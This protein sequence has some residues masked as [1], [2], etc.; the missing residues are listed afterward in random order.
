M[1]EMPAQA[2]IST[3]PASFE[4]FPVEVVTK[5]GIRRDS[6]SGPAHEGRPPR[7]W[8]DDKSG[9][10]FL[11]RGLARLLRERGGTLEAALSIRRDLE[12]GRLSTV[13]ID[14]DCGTREPIPPQRWE[15]ATTGAEMYLTGRASM[16]A[17]RDFWDG[18]YAPRHAEGDIYLTIVQPRIVA[19]QPEA[20]PVPVLV[21]SEP[22][23]A[24]WWPR[25][26]QTLVNWATDP[27]VQREAE[28]RLKAAGVPVTEAATTRAMEAMAIE[29]ER[30]WA[31]QS[32]GATRRKAR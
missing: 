11:H 32:I 10:E 22:R 24:D 19:V 15:A 6:L 3:P 12:T 27:A 25:P 23:L 16:T 17:R 13:F 31:D 7:N 4:A 8:P 21:K 30:P 20:A 5:L 1:S 28:R 29:A 14:D 26:A 2:A 9:A 18:S